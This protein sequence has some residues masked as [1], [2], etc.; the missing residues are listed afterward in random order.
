VNSGW[1]T[2]IKVGSLMNQSS[3]EI[4]TMR[5]GGGGGRLGLGAWQGPASGGQGTYP[6]EGCEGGISSI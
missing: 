6:G 5:Y 4:T 2:E 3:R 1:D